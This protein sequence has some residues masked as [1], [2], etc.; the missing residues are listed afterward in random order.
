MSEGALG[1]LLEVCCGSA[2]FAVRKGLRTSM[3]VVLE[4]M[5]AVAV[6]VTVRIVSDAECQLA[7]A[8]VNTNS[9]VA[10]TPTA[11]FLPALLADLVW[12]A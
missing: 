10:G 9:A 4:G 6:A 11:R 5:L 2:R 8:K 1:P 7:A 12:L 3:L